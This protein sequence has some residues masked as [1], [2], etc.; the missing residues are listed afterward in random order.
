MENY[1]HYNALLE[2]SK[3]QEKWVHDLANHLS[4]LN[5][6]TRNQHLAEA[7]DYIQ[8]LV[9]YILKSQEEDDSL[10][11]YKKQLLNQLYMLRSLIEFQS[12]GDALLY[13]RHMH[14]QLDTVAPEIYCDHPLLNAVLCEKRQV[15]KRYLIDISYNISL[16]KKMDIPAP[17]L[18]SIFFNLL[19]NAI[20][21]CINASTQK[22]FI[23]L[24]TN[25]KGNMVS[26]RMLNSKN[27][28]VEFTGK[29]TK[30]NISSHGLGLQIIEDAIKDHLGYSKW[31]D[32]GSVFE[33][34]LM[35][36]IS[37]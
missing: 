16:P 20:E 15:C 17:Q 10:Q 28:K 3:K 18:L 33:S 37:D 27:P 24:K 1:S 31:M 26:I 22:P 23:Q 11:N 34:I 2:N 6:L 5:Y 12:T 30:E 7:E 36:K 8:Q 21:A 32:H 35:F 9:S 19:D 13:I 25:F 14:Q 29:T 4:T